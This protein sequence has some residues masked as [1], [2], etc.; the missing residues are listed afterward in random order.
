MSKGFEYFHFIKNFLP[1][2]LHYIFVELLTFN[3]NHRNFWQKLSSIWL[4]TV[5]SSNPLVLFYCCISIDD[6]HI[7]ALS[8]PKNW[9]QMAVTAD[10]ADGCHARSMEMTSKVMVLKYKTK[11]IIVFINHQDYLIIWVKK[12][13]WREQTCE[14]R[15][16]THFYKR[17]FHRLKFHWPFFYISS[18]LY[19]SIKYS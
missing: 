6:L 2:L 3:V 12:L 18:Y 16:H 17:K 19:S 1:Y 4:T 7:R 11:D 13:M 9:R 10:E 15:K 5:L 8:Q 14:C